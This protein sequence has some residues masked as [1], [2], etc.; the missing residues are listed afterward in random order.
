[1]T[2]RRLKSVEIL[3][4]AAQ[5]YEKS[6]LTRR[7]DLSCGIK[8]RRY[9][10]WISHKA[11]VWQTDRQN[12]GSQDRASIAASRD[13]NDADVAQYNFNAGNFGQRCFWQSMLS[14]GDL[15][16]CL[17]WRM[18][19]H[20]L[21][22]HEPQ[23]LYFQWQWQTWYSPTRHTSSD[24]N[25]I[26]HGG[27]SSGDSAKVRISSKSISGVGAVGTGGRSLPFPIDLAIDLYKLVIS[28]QIK[29]VMANGHDKLNR[30]NDSWTSIAITCQSA[31]VQVRQ[32]TS[33]ADSSRARVLVV[34]TRA[35]TREGVCIYFV[36]YVYRVIIKE[37]INR[38]I[39]ERI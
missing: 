38:R 18:S 35:I 10:L 17:S 4:A 12:Y 15:L 19:R 26:L 1:M 34:A 14:N 27:L 6:H 20:Y 16:S 36:L 13:K 29:E 5:L 7:I 31:H 37:Q 9:D 24:R 8:Y 39:N 11:R 22:K 21:E 2:A 3:S 32:Q 25:E 33:G 23:K 30:L 28:Q